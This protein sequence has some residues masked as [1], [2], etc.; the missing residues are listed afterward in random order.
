MKIP[1]WEIVTG[2]VTGSA[3]FTA[4]RCLKDSKDWE[5][6][7]NTAHGAYHM[8]G[9]FYTNKSLEAKLYK[10]MNALGYLV[11]SSYTVTIN[12]KEDIY[13]MH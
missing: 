8:L 7:C 10:D 9:G 3:I 13:Y 1:L 2:L 12:E 11:A 4:A 5:Y 6:A